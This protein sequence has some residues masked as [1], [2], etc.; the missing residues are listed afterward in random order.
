M[1]PIDEVSQ[2]ED[3]KRPTFA[4]H[5]EGIREAAI[6]RLDHLQHDVFHTAL[7]L[8]G[9]GLNANLL[10]FGGC[11]RDGLLSLELNLAQLV[12][13]FQ[14]ALLSNHLVFNGLGVLGA[15]LQIRYRHVGDVDLV[16]VQPSPQ[17][18]QDVVSQ[19]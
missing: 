19:S 2:V 12:L 8:D 1:L 14:S 9:L 18:G 4:A 15:E 7:S 10:G 11:D 16:F 5:D 13:S 6:P 3:L 17:I